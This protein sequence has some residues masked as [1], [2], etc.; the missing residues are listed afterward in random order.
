MLDLE[1]LST[2][3]NALIMSIGAVKFDADAIVDR[4]E[5]GIDP[6]NAQRFGL[7]IDAGTVMYWFDPERDEARK[8]IFEM[9][10]VDLIAGLDGFA[11]W[12]QQTPEESQGSL[13]GNGATFDNVVI[14]SGFAATGVDD[15]FG[16]KKQECYRTLKNR[17][18]DVEFNDYQIGTPHYALDDASSQA[19]HLI[20]ICKQYGIAL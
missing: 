8:R 20:A 13:W 3:N 14:Q 18:P 11:Q 2:A 5:V 15:P 4:F 6:A 1:T 16:Y 19:L 17:C 10:R 9:A 7:H 12:C